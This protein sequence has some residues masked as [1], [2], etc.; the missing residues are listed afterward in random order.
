M[1]ITQSLE[2]E[3]NVE[4]TLLDPK[5]LILPAPQME[6]DAIDEHSSK[7]WDFRRSKTKIRFDSH[8][9]II[10]KVKLF[11]VTYRGQSNYVDIT[12]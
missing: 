4:C 7:I 8:R 9:S 1:K 5:I 2:S 12:I 6:Y 10:S 11:I 3:E